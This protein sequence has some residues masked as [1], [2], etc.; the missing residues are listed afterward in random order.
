MLIDMESNTHYNDDEVQLIQKIFYAFQLENILA[1]LM[2]KIIQEYPYDEENIK[3]ESY[4]IT[5]NNLDDKNIITNKTKTK[6]DF[7]TIKTK[8]SSK[9]VKNNII[10]NKSNKNLKEQEELYKIALEKMLRIIFKLFIA[11]IHNTSP[12]INENIIDIANFSEGYKYLF[13]LGLLQL[14]IELSKD[15]KYILYNSKYLITLV[16]VKI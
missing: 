9:S 12:N 1:S 7:K 4:Q 10:Q 13:N 11:L 8:F 15:E 16:R 6:N 2:K 5:I 3:E 14:I